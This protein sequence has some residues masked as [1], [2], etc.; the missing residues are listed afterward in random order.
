MLHAWEIFRETEETRLDVPHSQ[1]FFKLL[2][3]L[4][5]QIFFFSKRKEKLFNS[6]SLYE[7]GKNYTLTLIY[8]GLRKLK[9]QEDGGTA[10]Q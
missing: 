7:K 2:S 5:S 1:C 10:Y 9:L 6:S 8:A 3:F 4:K